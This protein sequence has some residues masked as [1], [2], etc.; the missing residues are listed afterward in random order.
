MPL[1]SQV[2]EIMKKRIQLFDL[3]KEIKHA[4]YA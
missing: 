2:T 3:A 1:K 4:T